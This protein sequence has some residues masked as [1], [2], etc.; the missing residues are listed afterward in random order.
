MG[1]TNSSPIDMNK[2]TTSILESIKSK[3]HSVVSINENRFVFN[4][5]GNVMV[6]ELYEKDSKGKICQKLPDESFLK[7]DNSINKNI[8]I[9][10]DNKFVRLY[11]DD[12][13]RIRAN[14]ESYAIVDKPEADLFLPNFRD[15]LGSNTNFTF[16]RYNNYQNAHYYKITDVPI[17]TPR[18]PQFYIKQ[19]GKFVNK[20]F[21]EY[22]DARV[23]KDNRPTTV[24]RKIPMTNPTNDNIH[25][26]YRFQPLPG[27]NP[28]GRE[29]GIDRF[30]DELNTNAN[31]TNPDGTPINFLPITIY[32]D[33]Y[34]DVNDNV[35][36][37]K[38]NI[39]EKDSKNEPIINPDNTDV[40]C[41]NIHTNDNTKFPISGGYRL[42]ENFPNDTIPN[43]RPNQRVRYTPIGY[44]K[45]KNYGTI[46]ADRANSMYYELKD[47]P[48]LID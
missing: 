47:E 20:Q 33:V 4:S 41:S 46:V 38:G 37:K 24:C 22:D 1:V 35:I 44:S 18:V 40:V 7:N 48:G 45:V 42:N 12:K 9:T 43:S 17:N 27:D 32:T 14:E 34:R 26:D 8:F 36:D 25:L 15:T 3:K 6:N 31:A 39:V 5:P 19:S 30:P 23:D 29:V 16:V 11:A 21:V 2:E 10:A 28:N 13:C